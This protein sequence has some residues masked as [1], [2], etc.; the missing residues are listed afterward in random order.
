M[1]PFKILFCQLFL[2]FS[3]PSSWAVSFDWSGWA[4]LDSYYQYEGNHYG[5]FH[6][7]L[8]SDIFITDSLSFKSRIDLFPFLKGKS[9]DESYLLFETAY[10]QTG[11]VFW[12]KEEGKTALS[13]LPLVFFLPTQFYV[14]YQEEFFK[15][16]LGRAPYH[17]GLGTT[18]SATN[19]PFEHWMSLYNQLSVHVEYQSIYI[20]PA[21]LHGGGSSSDLKLLERPLSALLQA[22]IQQE[23][24]RLSALYQHVFGKDSLIELFGEYEELNW[25]VKASSSYAFQPGVHFSLA[26][27]GQMK[28]PS[29][30]PIRLEL[31]TGG[32]SG[33]LAFHPNYDLALLFWNRWMTGKELS[34]KY[35]YQI[36]KGQAQ[37]GVY[38]SPRAV[39]SFLDEALRIQPL[40]LLAGNLEDKKLNYE[41]DLKAEY[42]LDENLFF[43]LTA[44]ALYAHQKVDFSLLAQTAASF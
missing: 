14:D 11:F 44:G 40:F 7:V 13:E 1:R 27:E 2:L 10:R 9:L 28:L 25:D 19:N 29:S 12:Y 30:I 43:S 31:K 17:F 26:L 5:S 42:Q 38:F 18:Y 22:G 16:R 21:L 34:S 15:V 35:P 23:S 20:Q 33:D 41:M 6:S 24:W 32:L 8:N 4:R 3:S 36:A 39:F 37:N